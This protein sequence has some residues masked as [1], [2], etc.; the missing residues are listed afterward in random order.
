[1]F[2]S[3]FSGIVFLK[4]LVLGFVFGF[5][6][7]ICK[8]TKLISKNNIVIVNIVNLIYFCVLAT[9]HASFLY[10]ICDFKIEAYTIVATILGILIEQICVGIFF[11]K[12]YRLVYNVYA[13]LL[14][15]AKSTRVGKN[16]LR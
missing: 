3:S 10:N 14:E 7:E 12:F 6:Y 1:M 8:I 16:I 11:T 15:R 2:A 5:I 4:F 13:K 9:M